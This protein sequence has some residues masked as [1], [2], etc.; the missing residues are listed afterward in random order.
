MA[1]VRNLNV[2]YKVTSVVAA[3]SSLLLPRNPAPKV[4]DTRGIRF[5]FQLIKVFPL[6]QPNVARSTVPTKPGEQL[7]RQ[8][9]GS[10][11]FIGR[12]YQVLGR[13]REWLGS[14]QGDETAI[15]VG[16]RDQLIGRIAE[17]TCVSIPEAEILAA[18]L[19]NFPQ[20]FA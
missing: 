20:D 19:D 8:I 11:Y 5:L 9:T 3:R 18:S 10:Y 13:I 16:R 7:M 6:Y 12:Y 17:R 4:I 1:F 2:A 14:K 15:E